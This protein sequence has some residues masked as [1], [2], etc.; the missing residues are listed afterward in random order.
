LTTTLID[1][2]KNK[3]L[4]MKLTKI[5]ILAQ[6]ALLFVALLVVA[7]GVEA[8]TGA[9]AKILNTVSINYYD[10]SGTTTYAA[11][12]STSVTVNLVKAALTYSGRP[13]TT[14]KGATASMPAGLTIDSGGT[15]TYLIA[16][17]ANANGGDTYTITDAISNVVNMNGTNYSVTW[18]TVKPDGST[19]ITGSSPSTVSIGASIIQANDATHISIP[20]GSN[21]SALITSGS[22]KTLVVNNVD[23]LVSGIVTGTAPANTHVG[24]TYYNNTG[25]AT[26][27]VL[28]VITLAANPSGANVTPAFSVNAL[29]GFVAAEQQLVLV[30][31]TGVVG[32]TAG[33]DGTVAFTLTTK[34]STGGNSASM[35]TPITTTFRGSNLQVQ[36]NVRNCGAAGTSCGSFAAS[37]TGNPG[38]ILE[39]QVKVNNAGASAAKQVTASDAVPVY[40][41]LVCGTSSAFGVATVCPSSGA[42]A[43][44]FAT[45]T[46][47]T[48]TTLIPYGGGN[49][50]TSAGVGAGLAAGY[51][52]TSV[53][54]YYFGNTTTCNATTGGTVNAGATY[55]ITYRVKMN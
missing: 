52:E 9:G 49:T 31:V 3:E 5:I 17:T 45:I 18:A 24:A 11:N 10:A 2:D 33:T 16:L 6:L 20:G 46:D 42:S 15:Q 36:K 41:Q 30:S 51:V 39:Y 27:E 26:A 44:I 1:V 25:T 43:L 55:T 40:T 7:P 12:A 28:D 29:K 13:T 22:I 14:S 32:S 53:L 4:F 37:V 23:Y 54:N 8:N 19:V 35:T 48:T 21:V 47:G 38:D 34:D 50:C